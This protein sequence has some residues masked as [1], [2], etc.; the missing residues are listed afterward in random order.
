M[1]KMEISVIPVG[2]S[3]VS[4]NKWVGASEEALRGAQD[5]RSQVTPMGTILEGDSAERLFSLAKQMHQKAFSS[6]I[7]R[8]FTTIAIDQRVDK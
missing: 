4:M 2:T 6:G 8:V 3:E 1:V 5:V 7:K